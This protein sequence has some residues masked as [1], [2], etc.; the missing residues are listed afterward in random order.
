MNTNQT[1]SHD[2]LLTDCERS[3]RYHHERARFFNK[4]HLFIQ[5]LVFALA[6]AS[7]SRLLGTLLTD[8]ILLW[9]L[10]TIGLL[11]LFSLVY[12]PADKSSIHK[13]LYRGFTMLNG[14]VAATPD[15]DEATLTEW[16]KSLHSLYAE[17]PPVYCALLAHCSNQVVLALGADRRYLVT[18]RWREKWLRNIFSFQG[19]EF[20]NQDQARS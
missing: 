10:A 15:P 5:F 11:A 8:Q 20:L 1:L 14:T 19:T 9:L 2:D 7:V 4:V 12:N 18:L 6:S 13:S 16:T 17:E 3:M